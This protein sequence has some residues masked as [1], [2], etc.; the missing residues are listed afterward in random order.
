M[1]SFNQLPKDVVWL[2][3]KQVIID[4]F[5]GVYYYFR[6]VPV[7]FIS[8]MFRGYMGEEMCELACVSKLFLSLVQTKTTRP[9]T[10]RSTAAT[11]W[12]FNKKF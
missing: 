8:F 4:Y 3:L 9:K 2:I 7:N 5:N 11:N 6:D 1:G 10:A 12:M